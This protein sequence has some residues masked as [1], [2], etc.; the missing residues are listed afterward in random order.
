MNLH[1]LL[2][3]FQFRSFPPARSGWRQIKTVR[4]APEVSTKEQVIRQFARDLQFPVWSGEN[5]D[6]FEE[7]LRSQLGNSRPGK[8]RIWHGGCP[9]LGS[10]ADL[11]TYCEILHDLVTIPHDSGLRFEVLFRKSERDAMTR[12]LS[13]MPGEFPVVPNS[14]ESIPIRG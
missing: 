10:P 5:W 7:S 3:P 13:E 1:P 8:I 6:A 14:S 2:T 4:I 9:L 11:L 12:L